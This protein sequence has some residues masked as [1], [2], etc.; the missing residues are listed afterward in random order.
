MGTPST[1]G[2]EG[3]FIVRGDSRCGLMLWARIVLVLAPPVS[4]N[5]ACLF[6]NLKATN[7]HSRRIHVVVHPPLDEVR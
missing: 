3:C 5:A 4:M 1:H 2:Q 7:R 6:R